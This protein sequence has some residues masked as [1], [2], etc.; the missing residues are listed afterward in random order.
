MRTWAQLALGALLSGCG[1][2]S[3]PDSPLR[4]IASDRVDNLLMARRTSDLEHFGGT[5][6][7]FRVEGR[8]LIVRTDEGDRTPIFL[9]EGEPSVT[10]TG[11]GI[12]GTQVAVFGTRYVLSG[13]RFQELDPESSPRIGTCLRQAVSFSYLR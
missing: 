11:I 6:G 10:A 1:S 9:A 12:D 7:V 8:C 5:S 3:G 13:H 2:E 4:R